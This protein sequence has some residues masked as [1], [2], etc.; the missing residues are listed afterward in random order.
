MLQKSFSANFA[1]G[2][3]DRRLVKSAME[4]L[5]KLSASVS[6][7]VALVSRRVGRDELVAIASPGYPLAVKERGAKSLRPITA[8][9]LCAQPLVLL[10]PGSS[11][12]EALDRALATCGEQAR[13]VALTLASVEAVKAMVAADLGMAVLS[14]LSVARELTAGMLVEVPVRNFKARWPLTEITLRNRRASSTVQALEK[15]L[16]RQARGVR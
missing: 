3:S 13:N 12:R 1:L 4:N 11:L 6:Y 5:R 14:R 8:R 7:E 16:G 2:A 10:E 9:L 15:L